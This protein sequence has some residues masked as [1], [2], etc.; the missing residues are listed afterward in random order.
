MLLIS[1]TNLSCLPKFYTVYR[2]HSR[3]NNTRQQGC[4]IE[5]NYLDFHMLIPELKTAKF[6]RDIVLYILN[7]MS[8]NTYYSL[9]YIFM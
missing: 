2:L 1:A 5:Q 4:G 9:A 3:E 7:F 6:Y 8:R